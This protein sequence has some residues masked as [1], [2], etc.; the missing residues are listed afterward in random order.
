MI[1]QGADFSMAGPSF[2]SKPDTPTTLF[3]SIRRQGGSREF[4]YFMII[5]LPSS[6]GGM[7]QNTS[8]QSHA[9]GRD[10][11]VK[12]KL[13][14]NGKE[15]VVDYQTTVRADSSSESETLLVNAKSQPLDK[16]RVF[17][18]DMSADPLTIVPHD[19]QLPAPTADATNPMLA[20][21]QAQPVLKLLEQDPA[22]AEFLQSLR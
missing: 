10:G 15:L 2:I 22:V 6:A 4:V 16:G 11:V 3:A 20:E 7:T 9:I 17:L 1:P 13:T 19:I 18:V 8:G 21:K 5:K 14:N 12:F